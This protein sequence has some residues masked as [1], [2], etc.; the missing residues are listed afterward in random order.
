MEVPQISIEGYTRKAVGKKN[1]IQGDLKVLWVDVETTGLVPGKHGIFQMAFI[2]EIGG[3]VVDRD[4]FF[5]NPEGREFDPKALEV[6]GYTEERIKSFP[7][8]KVAYKRI[9]SFLKKWVNPRDKTDKFLVAGQN[10]K[11]DVD[12]WMDF[13]K[14]CEDDYLYSYIKSGAFIDTLYMVTVLQWAGILPLTERRRNEDLAKLMGVE[15]S[16]VTLHNALEDIELTRKIGNKMLYYIRVQNNWV[17]SR[18]M[19]KDCQKGVF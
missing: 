5:M 4:N 8:W 13:W 3:K 16:G 17:S 2:V 9:I 14:A 15:L 12:F 11:F 18:R 1:D 7:N 10:V 19:E 6:T